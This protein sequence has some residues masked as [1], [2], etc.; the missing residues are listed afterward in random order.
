MGGLRIRFRRRWTGRAV[1]RIGVE[2]KKSI[3]DDAQVF[4]ASS[5]WVAV[6]EFTEAELCLHSF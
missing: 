2:G 5:E 4:I 1:G 3:K 6:P